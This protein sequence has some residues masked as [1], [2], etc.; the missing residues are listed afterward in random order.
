MLRPV[1]TDSLSIISKL[2]G[3]PSTQ[4]AKNTLR[5][6]SIPHVFV[7]AA[8]FSLAL[9]NKNFFCFHISQILLETW[10]S[11]QALSPWYTLS[12]VSSPHLLC[13]IKPSAAC[14][15]FTHHPSF[16]AKLPAYAMFGQKCPFYLQL[17]C[18]K[19]ALLFSPKFPLCF[20]A[21]FQKQQ[22]NSQALHYPLQTLL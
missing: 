16:S 3:L 17:P 1:Y 20:R 8:S 11:S 4:A 14:H 18:Y 12:L 10:F 13:H 15:H 9:I 7:H 5:G 2:C 6:F 19:Q 21:D 22:R